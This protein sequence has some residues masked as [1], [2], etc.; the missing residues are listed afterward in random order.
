MAN[1]P[2]DDI[3]YYTEIR[4]VLG[5]DDTIVS[6]DAIDRDVVKGQAEREVKKAVSD[7]ST[8]SGDDAA[9]LRT[10]VIYR[11]CAILCDR[12]RILQPTEEVIGDYEYV[13]ANTD[14]SEMAARF[15]GM[16]GAAVMSISTYVVTYDGT[17]VVLATPTTVE[18]IPDWGYI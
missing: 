13:L 16:M 3:D 8:L 14:W 11:I 2:L 4:E 17:Q 1:L 18:N 12:F 15:D 6:D 10:A 7:W 5:I 9:Q